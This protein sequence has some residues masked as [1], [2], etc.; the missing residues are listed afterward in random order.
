MDFFPESLAMNGSEQ[1]AKFIQIKRLDW[2]KFWNSQ[3]PV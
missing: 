1:P 2:M 3:S